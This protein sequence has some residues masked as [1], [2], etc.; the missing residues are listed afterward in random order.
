MVETERFSLGQSVGGA[1]S[2]ESQEDG[3]SATFH[4]LVLAPLRASEEH[5][6]NDSWAAPV[7]FKRAEFDEAMATV[8]PS[9]EIEVVIGGRKQRTT[10]AFRAMKSFRPD[11]LMEQAVAAPRA[12]RRGASNVPPPMTQVSGRRLEPRRR[13]AHRHRARAR[14]EYALDATLSAL[15]GASRKC[16]RSSAPGVGLAIPRR[17][18]IGPGRTSSSKRWTRPRTTSRGVLEKLA[19][20]VGASTKTRDRSISSSSTTRSAPRRAISDASRNGRRSR[21]ASA[22]R[23][24]RTRRRSSSARIRSRRS[25]RA[26][27][28]SVRRTIRA[29]PRSAPRRRRT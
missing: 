4:V 26:R 28:A 14:A 3:A 11:V 21:K 15:V 17:A 19:R 24:S 5:A 10:H 9:F 29:R 8:A 25:A 27:A 18:P 16:A 6:T 23:S 13:H 1:S 7:R 12:P 22:R 20:R 2:G